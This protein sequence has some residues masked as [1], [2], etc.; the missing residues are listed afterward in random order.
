METRQLERSSNRR[1]VGFLVKTYPKLSETF[2]LGEI[3]GLQK[4]GL[5]MGIYSMQ[6][7]TDSSVHAQTSEVTAQVAYLPQDTELP[8]LAVLSA[9]LKMLLHDPRRY[10]RAL[11]GI[12]ASRHSAGLAN[13]AKAGWLAERLRRDRVTHLHAHFA[14]E[15]ASV[16]ELVWSLTGIPYSISAHAK[17]IYLSNS[18]SLRRK[19]ANARFTVTCTEHNREYLESVAPPGTRILRMY[20]GIDVT[21]FSP[22]GR[23]RERTQI[24][25]LL[26]V[27]R[28]RAKKG[29]D[30]LIAA[31]GRLRD[32]GLDF[33]CNIIGYGPEESNLRQRIRIDHLDDHVHLLGKLTHDKVVEQYRSASAFVLPCRILE[34]GDRDGIPNVLLE[35]MAMELPVVSTTVSGI[36]EAVEHGRN[37]LLVDPG[38]AAA[39]AAA[40]ACLLAD[41]ALR[42]RLGREGRRT[43][44]RQFSH[45]N[46]EILFG[47]L[48]VKKPAEKSRAAGDFGAAYDL[49]G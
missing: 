42:A 44:T 31:C 10:C 17:D 46:L 41:P 19:L 4:A 6:R 28:L 13:F 21:R 8:S 18:S 7:P 29:L 33:R 39:I 26:S 15:P 34:D 3:L 25:L 14:S 22:G 2:I 32:Q 47:L 27:G 36:P 43:V 9:H 23:R 38:D 37:G 11:L 35:A 1:Q 24:P 48:P 30:T 5:R 45:G 20:H 12:V 49:C 40:L 16:A